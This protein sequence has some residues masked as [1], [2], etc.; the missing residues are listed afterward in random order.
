MTPG[1]GGIRAQMGP[2]RRIGRW[3]SFGAL[4][5][6]LFL[7]FVIRISHS[8]KAAE[9]MIVFSAE[10]GSSPNPKLIGVSYKTEYVD[11]QPTFQ[12]LIRFSLT[13]LSIARERQRSR[14]ARLQYDRKNGDI[15][16]L[17]L[18]WSLHRKGIDASILPINF[19]MSFDKSS[20]GTTYV[21]DVKL[22]INQLCWMEEPAA[23][24]DTWRSYGDIA[25]ANLRALGKDQSSPSILGCLPTG[26][27][28]TSSSE[29]KD[30]SAYS[31]RIARRSLIKGFGIFILLTF[32][33]GLVISHIFWNLTNKWSARGNGRDIKADGLIANIINDGALAPIK[34]ARLPT[35][36][37]IHSGITAAK[38]SES[39][40]SSDA[41]NLTPVVGHFCWWKRQGA[42]PRPLASTAPPAPDLLDLA[43]TDHIVELQRDAAHEVR[44]GHGCAAT[45]R[46]AARIASLENV[47]EPSSFA[48]SNLL[49][50]P[51]RALPESELLFPLFDISCLLLWALWGCG[52]RAR[53]VRAQRQIHRALGRAG[54]IKPSTPRAGRSV[55]HSG[56]DASSG[57]FV[58]HC[59]SLRNDIQ[60]AAP[61]QAG[62]G[63]FGCGIGHLCAGRKARLHRC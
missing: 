32:L 44:P 19:A 30:E 42:K 51:H 46:M 15:W 34:S 18:V 49:L 6:V 4:F 7:V 26:I 27:R 12:D 2:N 5:G 35:S 60:A 25:N 37:F 48:S 11:Q 8:E 40:I 36:T 20:F 59:K 23:A 50:L 54:V 56:A 31:D 58:A 61:A 53:V 3:T 22:T 17:A 45:I 33:T 24:K 1:F 41:S 52:R 16:I 29:S 62:M 47:P 9:H 38:N 13:N 39:Y 28:K 21:D 63:S 10:C 55:I 57:T 14:F 43:L